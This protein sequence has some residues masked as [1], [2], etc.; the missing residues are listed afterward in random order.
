MTN[1]PLDTQTSRLEAG[2]GKLHPDM[3]TPVFS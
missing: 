3:A 2:P 1:G